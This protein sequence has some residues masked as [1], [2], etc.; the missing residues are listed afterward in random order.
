MSDFAQRERIKLKVGA[1]I[2]FIKNDTSEEKLYFNGKLAR[3]KQIDGEDITVVM[4]GTDE[5]FVLR[6]EPWENKKYTIDEKSKELE[7]EVIGTF[8]QYPIK[9]AW[10]VTVH[11][12][13]GLTFEKAIIDVGRAF[14]PG[15]IYV[16]LSRLQSLEGLVLRTRINTSSICSDRDVVA[17]TRNKEQQKPLP[18]IL[19]EQQR[20]FL[21][22]LLNTT[23]DFSLN[24][25]RL[26]IL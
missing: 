9:L 17:F 6:K 8:S 4:S 13:Q 25:L 5:L 7:E 11:K 19:Q 22:P 2:M 3:V 18:V 16:A 12:S 23:F 26:T 1:Q 21:E 15:Q 10:A 14:A 24:Y 20:K